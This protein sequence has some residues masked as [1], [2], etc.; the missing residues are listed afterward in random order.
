MK[1]N[2]SYHWSIIL[3]VHDFIYSMLSC[4]TPP[5]TAECR[6][7]HWELRTHS[8]REPTAKTSSPPG[9]FPGEKVRYKGRR[10]LWRQLSLD[11]GS[12]IYRA[13]FNTPSGLMAEIQ[14]HWQLK[15]G[16][17]QG[18][19]CEEG[20]GNV[21]R[22]HSEPWESCYWKTHTQHGSQMPWT[23]GLLVLPPRRLCNSGHT[24]TQHQQWE[25]THFLSLWR[26]SEHWASRARIRERN[27]AWK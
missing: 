14:A 16:N 25:W 22:L 18:Q 1:P 24:R 19:C 2:C 7:T 26:T 3:A 10:G 13:W 8:H 17:I 21:L 12:H 20:K 27:T 6:C 11:W 23:N 9:F 15:P 4:S 5:G